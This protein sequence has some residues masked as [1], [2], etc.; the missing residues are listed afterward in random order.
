M[1]APSA[2]MTLNGK[3][4]LVTQALDMDLDVKSTATSAV[5]TIGAAA[6]AIANPLVG[7]AVWLAGQMFNPLEGLGHYRYHITGTW[8]KPVFT[9]ISD[10][11]KPP[12]EA[13]VQEA[14]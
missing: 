5:P 2:N 8:Q 7:A 1:K 12:K 11:I 13:P 14:R 4:N 9:D 3:V 6:V 10:Q